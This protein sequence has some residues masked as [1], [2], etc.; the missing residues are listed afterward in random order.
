LNCRDALRL[1]YDVIDNEANESEMATVK[2][3]INKCHK[4]AA[5]YELEQ[6]FKECIEK[7]GKFSP[8]CDE[9]RSKISQQLD[10]LD[11]ALGESD[12]FPSPF[13]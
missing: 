13:G 11:T 2:E 7:K 4:C 6:K 10:T 9:L 1:L 12:L 8:E 3:H 5:Q